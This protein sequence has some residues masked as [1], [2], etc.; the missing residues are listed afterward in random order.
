LISTAWGVLM[1]LR[2]GWSVVWSVACL[3]AAPGLAR[4]QTE[5]SPSHGVHVALV[6]ATEGDA[7]AI[8]SDVDGALLRD[9]AAIAGIENPTVSPIDYAEIQLTVG[10]SDDGRQC[11]SSIAQLVQVE[12]VVVRRL[13][14][15]AGQLDLTLMYFDAT[16]SD[17]PAR[18]DQEFVGTDA[19]ERA[20]A[21]I[22]ALV[23]K[24][25]GVPEPVV[26]ADAEPAV[27]P[28]SARGE[29]TTPA[30]SSDNDS[31]PRIGAFTWITL[32][33]GVG[34]LGGGIALGASA[35]S[36]FDSYQN[37]TLQTTSDVT[38]ANSKLDSAKTKALA[39]DVMMPAGG[40]IL[41]LGG[42]LLT[43]DLLRRDKAP[44]VTVLPVRG[45][46]MISMRAVLRGL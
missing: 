26:A 12:A 22:P 27:T 2:Y 46:A 4:A 33:A 25:F 32:A 15:K 36:S 20:A 14:V 29:L 3:S 6:R 43:L 19:G 10:C 13:S 17:E 42:V 21:A 39:A 38:R 8:A 41:A 30:S 23:R 28:S 37:F 16:S 1:W 5:A 44:S 31:A 7:S 11:L 35:Q 18:V 34:V 45:G 40:A 9:L 24:L